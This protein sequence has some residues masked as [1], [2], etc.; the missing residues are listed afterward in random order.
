MARQTGIIKIQGSIG[1]VS[2]YKTKNGY[3]AR[4]KGGIDGRRIKNDPAFRR[5]RENGREFGNAAKEARLIREALAPLL[6]YGKDGSA[7]LRLSQIM[8]ALRKLD[9]QS[10]RGERRAGRALESELVRTQLTGFNFN[11]RAVLSSI[12]MAPYSAVL[13]SGELQFPT[14]QIVN[15]VVAPASATHVAFIAGMA[16]I[17]FTEGTYALTTGDT[18]IYETGNVQTQTLELTTGGIPPGTGLQLLVLSVRFSQSVNN[19]L[20]DL[21]N[22]AFNSLAIVATGWV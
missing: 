12:V 19:A 9:T 2:F 17:N 18:V 21:N 14:M 6:Q 4:E 10:V 20:Y 11:N 3:L 16:L 8:M 7:G 22:G 1:D 13:Q 5:T 15:Q